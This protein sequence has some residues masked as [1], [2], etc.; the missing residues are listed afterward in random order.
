MPVEDLTNVLH[1][2]TNKRYLHEIVPLFGELVP[3]YKVG[4]MGGTFLRS[5]FGDGKK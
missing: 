3:S 1:D 4:S 5:N 2:L